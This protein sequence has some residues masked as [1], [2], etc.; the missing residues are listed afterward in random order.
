MHAMLTRP[1]IR[2]TAAALCLAAP[3]AGAQMF[4]DPALEALFKARQFVELERMGQQR[5]AGQ[6]DDRQAV[7]AL[8][9]AVQQA[10]STKARREAAIARAEACT[11]R[12]PQAAECHFALGGAL[13][14][15]AVNEGLM[16]M[17]GSA[18]RV[19]DALR[20]ALELSPGWYAARSAMV[21]FYVVAPGLMGGS[22][23]KALQAARGA[24]QPEQVRALQA[25]IDLSADKPE[26]ALAVLQGLAPG[27]DSVLDSDVR[28]WGD[29]AAFALLNAG[30]PARARGWFERA[31]RERPAE[32]R[33][34][35][36]LG[37]V[38]AESQAHAEA[39]AWYDKARRLEGAAGLPIDYRAGLSQQ[40]LG[41]VAAARESLGRYVK[42]GK[43]PKKSLDDARRRLE[44]LGAS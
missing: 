29:G 22:R 42:A 2:L 16:T 41:Q 13:G 7:L 26:P 15:H 38:H 34:A 19:H 25:F 11:D 32:A 40:A 9:V 18:G 33:P 43:G 3:V 5:L 24:A 6:A 4:T 36:G 37:R 20:R 31:L 28:Q 30:Q 17:A 8:A 23:D 1:L 27:G 14:V 44:Q 35:Y 39:L 10:E 12:Q 21:T